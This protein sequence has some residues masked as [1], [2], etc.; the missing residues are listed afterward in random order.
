MNELIER[1][2]KDKFRAINLFSKCATSGEFD[3]PVNK[4]FD[5]IK[6]EEAFLSEEW[7]NFTEEAGNELRGYLHAN[8]IEQYRNWNIYAQEANDFIETFLM[9]K[10][11]NYQQVNKIDPIFIDCVKSDLAFSMLYLQYSNE[12]E[13]ELPQFYDRIFAIYNAGY[14]PCGWDLNSLDGILIVI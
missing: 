11:V 2:I 3:F 6:A 7:E 9:D 12:L 4:L 13:E 8:S 5:W 14:F 1:S 10:I